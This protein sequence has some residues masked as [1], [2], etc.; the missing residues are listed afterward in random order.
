[1]DKQHDITFQRFFV[2]QRKR[3]KGRK[4]SKK[5]ITIAGIF[6][7]HAKNKEV[8]YDYSAC[9]NALMHRWQNGE[10]ISGLAFGEARLF[11]K[12]QELNHPITETR[13]QRRLKRLAFI[14]GS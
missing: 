9:T 5:H 12:H 1:M 14:N 6:F 3:A 13:K 11:E 4:G 8:T 10:K 2:D 7:D